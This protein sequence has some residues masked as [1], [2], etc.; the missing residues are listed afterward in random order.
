MTIFGKQFSGNKK[1]LIVVVALI[2]ILG[3]LK[4]SFRQNNILSYDY[5]GLYLYLPATFIYHDPGI[6]NINW[7]EEIN[8]TY[9]NTPML[10]QVQPEG[11][12][13]LIRFFCGIAILL[14][15]FFFIGHAV[16]LLTAY[17]ADGFSLPYQLAMMLAALFYVALGLVFLRKVL[18]RYFDDAATSI[19]LI[20]LYLG[21]NLFFWT[22]FNAGAPHTILLSI[23]AMLLWFT[24]RWHDKPTKFDAAA[25]GL[26]LG[27]IIVSRPSD[28]IAVFV[29]LLWN[30][31][32]K[33][34]LR[35]KLSFI[36]QNYLHVFILVLFTF[37]AGLPQILYYYTFTGK[38]FL[39]TYNDPSSGFNFSNPRF[40]WVLFSFQK[41]WFIYA[42][43]MI[44]SIVGLI[45][46][47]RKHKSV[48]TAIIAHLLLN[49][50]LLASFTSLIS[51][52]W[53]A[54]IQS[55]A[56][57]S[58]PLAAFISMIL[59]RRSLLPKI[60]AGLVLLFFIPWSVLQ[61]YQIMKEIIDPSRM[62][63]EYFVRII[64]KTKISPADMELLRIDPFLDD[65][66]GYKMPQNKEYWQYE[67]QKF[68]FEEPMLYH[69]K[70]MIADPADSANGVYQ[71]SPEMPYAPGVKVANSEISKAEYYW[72]RM[73]F[74]VFSETPVQGKE[75]LLVATYSYKGKK[76]KFKDVLYKYR[77]IPV[78][79]SE[80][81][82]WK[83]F[84][85]DYL[86]PNAVTPDDWLETYLW[87]RGSNNV[88]VDNF[89][90][91]IY[92]PVSR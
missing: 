20:A 69:E 55:Y 87:Y 5:F 11:S 83:T 90:V 39:S 29:P 31:Y 74:R 7:L 76:E 58:L 71:L 57:L 40:A 85:I 35:K 67:L 18:L 9:N 50:F 10:Y 16:A 75:L 37:L 79:I 68:D 43:L 24:I 30:I 32:D 27:L 72:A 56:L 60:F 64:G 84:T 73:T 34:S 52:G 2:I 19:T 23:Y 41:G 14:S 44:F 48:S 82:Q 65:N 4:F 61:G 45:P 36:R 13:N 46:L 17:P 22:T 6:S 25:I 12:Y 53:R 42:P 33:E 70:F 38:L 80:T 77:S 91:T 15:P 92:E 54:F 66:N 63:R 8:A 3:T 49:I 47:M 89:S 81:G 26:L 59:Q 1:S 78:V 86:A 51:Y 28:I 62:T 88:L 21:T